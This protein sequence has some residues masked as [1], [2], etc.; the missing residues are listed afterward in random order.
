LAPVS[1]RPYLPSSRDHWK[2]RLHLATKHDK[3][4]TI[5][6]MKNSNRQFSD[7]ESVRALTKIYLEFRL[8]LE[9]ARWASKADLRLFVE[10]KTNQIP[11]ESIYSPSS[12]FGRPLLISHELYEFADAKA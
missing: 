6:N 9:V 10:P 4:E 8:P 11:A 5:K 3:P 1:G 7:E 12:S 2:L